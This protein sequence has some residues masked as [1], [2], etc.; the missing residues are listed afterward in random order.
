MEILTNEAPIIGHRG[1][2]RAVFL[3]LPE[4]FSLSVESA[5]DNH[6]M[7]K[8]VVQ[9]DL[10]LAQSLALAA[11]LKKAGHVVVL[12]PGDSATPDA[13]FPNNAFATV[14]STGELG[15]GVPGCYLTGVM[16]H[17]ARQK[18]TKRTDMH[19]FFRQLLGYTR[20]DFSS[21]IDASDAAELTGCMVIDR[22]RNV[23]YCGL[24]SRCSRA[25]AKA[26]HEA[27]G[28]NKTYIFELAEGEYHTNVVL[29]ALGGKGL[30]IA[31]EGFAD[32]TDADILAGLYSE[33]CVWLSAQEKADFC[34]NCIALSAEQLW[35]SQR[36]RAA[37]SDSSQAAIAALGFQ[38]HSVELSELEKAGGSLR[39]MIGEIY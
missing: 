38:L 5:R 29:S 19:R 30:V 23:G 15:G 13:V 11:A 26:M 39:C 31:R 3:V 27:F 18:E 7:A 36:A 6:Y 4:Q 10:A 16:R 37:L 35:L 17:P 1:F 28:L 33:Q 24:S 14:E 32:P 8:T 21:A 20:V 22:T 2:P 9:A 34:A 25:G 12:F